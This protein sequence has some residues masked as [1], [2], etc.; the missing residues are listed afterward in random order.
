MDQSKPPVSGPPSPAQPWMTVSV[1]VPPHPG[2]MGSLQGLGL[3]QVS[4]LATISLNQ[5]PYPPGPY[6]AYTPKVFTNLAL[7]QRHT[8]RFLMY[9][10]KIT[11]HFRYGF[12]AEI[13]SSQQH[14]ARA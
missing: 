4:Q 10:S 12:P 14:E 7:G 5:S 3:G 11:G 2:G 6:P 8:S 9:S 1:A 13:R